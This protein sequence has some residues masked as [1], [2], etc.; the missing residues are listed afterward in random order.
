MI[1]ERILETLSV[2]RRYLDA[3]SRRRVVR[4]IRSRWNQ[5][6][7][8]RG[9]DNRSDLYYTVFALLCIR[10][11]RRPV[12]LL[13][14]WRYIHSF[15]D[16]Q[17]LDAVHLFC[18]IRLRTIFPI[19][20]ARRK[21]LLAAL[22][23]KQADSAYDAF[24]KVIAAEYLLE[25]DHPQVLLEVTPECTTPNLAAAVIVNQQQD[26]EAEV[27]LMERFCTSGGFRVSTTIPQA[28]LLSTATA[29]FALR[30][31]QVDLEP[32]REASL[33][34]VD[35]LWQDSGGFS[36]YAQDDFEDVEYTFYALLSIGCLME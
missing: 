1:V 31:M 14:L 5:D 8:V 32:V 21:R 15:G 35:S 25:S 6:G 20:T 27:L 7:G 9:R 19:S 11:L 16:G 28:D 34:F 26:P 30:W 2:A 22:E 12:P 18:L 24:F 4:F 23:S 3:G 13:R 10:A 33:D 36:G 29:L 17:A